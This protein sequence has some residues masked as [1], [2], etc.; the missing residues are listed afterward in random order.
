MTMREKLELNT[1]GGLV[2]IILPVYNTEAYLSK[3]LDSILCQSYSNLDVIAINDGSSD[4]SLGILKEFVAK[5]DRLRI[6]SQAN[7]G[8][9]V[10]R[11]VGLA[12][13]KPETEF[14]CFVDSDDWLP[15]DA[16]SKMLVCL[17]QK[18]VDMVCGLNDTITPDGR[19]LKTSPQT[20]IGDDNTISRAEMLALLVKHPI[21]KYGYLWA[22]LYKRHVFDDFR[23]IPGKVYEDSLC[24]RLYGNCKRIAFLNEI[25]YHYLKRPGSI[26][27]SDYDTRK[28]DQIEMFIDRIQYLREEGFPEYSALCLRQSIL[29]TRDILLTLPRIDATVIKHANS[30][31]HQLGLE[32][33]KSDLSFLPLRERFHYWANRFFFWP[34]LFRWR[35]H[36]FLHKKS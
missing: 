17:E 19:I 36:Q 13:L 31:L 1:S 35:V 20:I 8:I 18:Q 27:H 30:I 29:R 9:A 34:L 32:Y 6:L 33:K 3:C 25:V 22:R 11:N 7:A 12:A 21:P 16:I 10:T 14:V 28:F 15:V 2:S 24:H 5:D 23:F 4:G 26:V